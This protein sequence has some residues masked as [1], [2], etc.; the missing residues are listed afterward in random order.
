MII[1]R[2]SAK[3]SGKE[4]TRILKGFSEGKNAMSIVVFEGLS[5]L[6]FEAL[7]G[8]QKH[9]H[10]NSPVIYE[11]LLKTLKPSC[12]KKKQKE[13]QTVYDEKYQQIDTCRFNCLV[14]AN[15]LLSE[16]IL[17]QSLLIF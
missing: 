4:L 15:E 8:V 12:L 5:T 14:Q 9:L 6:I 1:N 17:F 7:R 3:D 13:E 2:L 11:L 16:Y 10:P